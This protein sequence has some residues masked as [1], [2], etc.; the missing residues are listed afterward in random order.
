MARKSKVLKFRRP[1][2]RQRLPAGPPRSQKLKFARRE[3]A[4]IPSILAGVLIAAAAAVF[5]V[6]ALE[7]GE[8]VLGASKVASYTPVVGTLH[9]VDGDSGTIDGRAFRL[10]G[11]DA[12]EGSLSLA[13][14]HDERM[15]ADAARSAVRMLTGTAKVEIRQYHGTDK[16][17][18]ELLTLSADGRDVASALVSSGDLKRWNYEGGAPK[19][20]WCD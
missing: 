4:A 2:S 1:G 14:C 15:K 11:V 5:A 10:Y 17:G 3:A 12:P 20:K 19:P 16:Y 8:I 6:S 9:W 18:R 13:Q 7:R